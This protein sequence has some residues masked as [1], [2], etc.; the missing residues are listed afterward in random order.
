MLSD[1]ERR[2]LNRRILEGEAAVD[3][4]LSRCERLET[5][6]AVVLDQMAELQELTLRALTRRG[7]KLTVE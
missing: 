6:L 5:H 7:E 4:A 2:E 1:D 3:A